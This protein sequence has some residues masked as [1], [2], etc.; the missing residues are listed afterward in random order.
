M[1]N[2][3][4]NRTATSTQIRN[5]YCSGVSYLNIRFFNTNLSFSFSRFKGQDETGRNSFDLEHAQTTSINYEQA[6]ALYQACHDLLPGK[7]NEC[8]LVL[9][10]P[11]NAKLVLHH[12][13]GS[14]GKP[15]T[16]LSIMKNGDTIPFHFSTQEQQIIENGT[17]TTKIIYSG[18]GALCKVIEGYLTGI[19]ADR[20]L[21]KMTEE[22]AALQ[23]G[24]QGG[25]QNQFQGQNRNQ[26]QNRG[27][28]QPRQYNGGGY[29][30]NRNR[31]YNGNNNNGGYRRQYQPRQDG[32]FPQA[33]GQNRNWQ[34]NQGQNN[35]QQNLSTYELPN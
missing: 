35:N 11:Q 16:T 19:N 28:Y 23:Q 26:Y 2:N 3:Y 12:E 8:N 32:G 7:I 24:Q 29:N 17:T 10:C 34:N 6:Y 18:V 13:T 20:H 5:M 9:D 15:K 25:Q 22:Y 30:G 14:D 27:Q 31:N 1:A 4:S 33:Q 21:D